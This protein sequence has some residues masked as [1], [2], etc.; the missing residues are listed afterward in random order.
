LLQVDDWGHFVRL[1]AKEATWL[2]VLFPFL[3]LGLVHSLHVKRE[4]LVVALFAG[5]YLG[6]FAL[7][8]FPACG[9]YLGPVRAPI[10]LLVF[11]GG[12]W[13]LRVPGTPKALLWGVLVAAF[14]FHA[15]GWPEQVREIKKSQVWTDTHHGEIGRRL[16]KNSPADAVVAVDNIGYIGYFSGRRILDMTGLIQKEVR[17]GI[18]R[19]GNRRYAIETFKPGWLAIQDR[20]ATPKYTPSSAWLEEH[21]YRPVFVVPYSPTAAYRVFQRVR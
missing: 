11:L 21:G 7:L 16:A 5:L 19:T 9:W 6:V 8:G 10:L 17:D 13:L 3:L 15:S 12:S 2:G 18:A 14:A 1:I 4:A 20:G